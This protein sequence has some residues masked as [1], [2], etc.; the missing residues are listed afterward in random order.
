MGKKIFILLTAVLIAGVVIPFF[1][2]PKP[3]PDNFKAP[4]NDWP[5]QKRVEDYFVESLRMIPQEAKSNAENGVSFY[6]T[7][8]TTLE[9]IIANLAYY[10][11]VRDEKT[12]RYALENTK[13]TS[14]GKDGAIKVGKEGTIDLAYYGLSRSMDAWQI[15]D[16]LLNK[17]HP[18]G[19]EYNYI[20]MPG[21][22]DIP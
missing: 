18:I 10:G 2:P 13:D 20:F 9:G 1:F 12:L 19:T 7:K 22:P 5:S 4:G 17:P 8:K 15:A 3:N 6:V 16:A 14:P 21:G 11:L